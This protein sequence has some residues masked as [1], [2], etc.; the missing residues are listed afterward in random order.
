MLTFPFFLLASLEELGLL[1]ET[2]A[3]RKPS[4]QVSGLIN[5]P[6]AGQCMG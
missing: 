2:S 6:H 1:L 5:I 4:E 3:S